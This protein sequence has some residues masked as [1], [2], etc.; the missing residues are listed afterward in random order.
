MVRAVT[1]GQS[2]KST[3]TQVVLLIRP[4]LMAVPWAGEQWTSKLHRTR[5]NAGQSVLAAMLAPVARRARPLSLIFRYFITR[6]MRHA[7]QFTD[8]LC[9]TDQTDL[10]NYLP[11]AHR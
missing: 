10:I 2:R 6:P 1:N 3:Y 9:V 5:V 8:W 4:K 11:S 7:G